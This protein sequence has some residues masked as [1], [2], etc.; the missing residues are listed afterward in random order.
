M[1]S[2]STFGRH[3]LGNQL[4]QYAFL[5][6]TARRLG[7]KFYCPPWLGD[8]VLALDDA[9][10]RAPAPAGISR[11]YIQP[12]RSCGFDELS[13]GIADH[14]EIDGHFQSPRFWTEPDDVRRWFAFRP[15]SV[16]AVMARYGH[17][18]FEDCAHL[19]IRFGDLDHRVRYYRPAERY[20]RTAIARART[21]SVLVFSDDPKRARHVL[22]RLDAALTFV[23]GNRAYEDLFLMSQCRAHVGSGSTFSWWGAW[24]AAPPDTTVI[25][26]RE[27]ATRPGNPVTAR[28]FWDPTWIQLPALSGFADGYRLRATMRTLKRRLLG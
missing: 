23:E 21:R 28:D 11:S 5:R 19:H 9:S 18:A 7:T 8:Q 3:G 12:H 13:L 15:E 6:T 25:V 10:E 4:F 16:A 26:P 27:G 2:Y 14:T 24:L 1:L 20:Y 17:I 22:R